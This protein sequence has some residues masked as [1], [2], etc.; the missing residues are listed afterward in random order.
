MAWLA[1]DRRATQV[2]QGKPLL[3]DELKKHLT[4]K[5]FHR[6]PNKRAVLLPALHL[7]Q[8]AYGHIPL[9]AVQEVAEFLEMSPAEAMDTATFYEEYWLRP[10][11]K[12]LIQVCR[13][14][15]C[16]VCASKELTKKMS[17][18]LRI[19][20]GET[21]ADKRFT[22]VELECLGSCGTAPVALVN[23][24]LH[25]NLTPEKLQKVIESLPEDPHEYKD[26]TIDWESG[27]DEAG[28]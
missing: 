12:Y 2:K 1:D 21:T 6:Y 13:S 20:L 26:P 4:E 18:M 23:D 10:K 8:H 17:Q 15:S 24:V 14:L 11:G 19:E 22:L 25:E 28:H 7:I 9:Q 27:E 16:E 5:Y 3:T